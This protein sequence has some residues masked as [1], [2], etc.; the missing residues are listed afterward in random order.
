MDDEHR[1]QDTKS[2]N[3]HKCYKTTYYIL[4]LV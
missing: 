1:G 3:A 4:G 2:Q